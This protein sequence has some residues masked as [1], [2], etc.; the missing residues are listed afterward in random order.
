MTD[1]WIVTLLCVAA[2][3]MFSVGCTQADLNIGGDN[4]DVR[5]KNRPT[6][7]GKVDSEGNIVA[8]F[9]GLG[10][11]AMNIDELG[12]YLA[13]PGDG[14]WLVYN[15]T[16]GVV[17]VWSPKDSTMEGVKFTPAPNPGEPALV[18]DKITMNISAP[19]E[20]LA[21]AFAEA[22]EA[23]IALPKDQAEAEVRKWEEAGK[24]TPQLAE[25]L[26]R[27]IVPLLGA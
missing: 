14:G 27:L 2:L 7:V 9:E 20:Q 11:T 1:T 8:A 13:T 5:I 16:T 21:G 15:P 18:A 26:I 10:G 6:N 23:I 3:A 22:V 4:E 25:V 17:V 24:I 19:R 12:G